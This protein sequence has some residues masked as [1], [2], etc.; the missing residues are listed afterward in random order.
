[1]C[2]STIADSDI[3]VDEKREKMAYSTSFWNLIANHYSKQPIADQSSY[4]KKLAVTQEY[5]T[6][7]SRVLE[8]G[9]GTG[10]TALI[11]APYVERYLAI[12]ISAKMLEIAHGK[13]EDSEFS[14]LSNLSFMQ[15]DLHHLNSE[16]ESWDM[17]MG[18]SILHLLPDLEQTLQRIHQ[19]L[20]PGGVF[21]SSTICIGDSGMG[22][23]LLA[24]LFRWMPIM[25]SVWVFSQQELITMM[26][27]VGFEVEY[28]WCPGT[29]KAVFIIARKPNP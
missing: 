8:F 13:V 19:L 16:D 17:V 9:C 21:I 27:Q 14:K 6:P 28:Q 7:E 11:H 10:S 12:D 23:K 2:M 4:E 20:K 24:P 26:E 3:R 29:N 22:F 18:M 25:P 15:T 5:F 1:M